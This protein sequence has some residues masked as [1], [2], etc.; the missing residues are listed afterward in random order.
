M[1]LNYDFSAP[2]L[3]NILLRHCCMVTPVRQWYWRLVLVD[4]L[5]LWVYY[6]GYGIYPG[7]IIVTSMKRE[8]SW[9]FIVRRIKRSGDFTKINNIVIDL[10]LQGIRYSAICARPSHWHRKHGCTCTWVP[11]PMKFLNGIPTM[12][13]FALKCFFFIL[14]LLS[15]RKHRNKSTR[16]PNHLPT[17]GHCK[18]TFFI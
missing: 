18:S 13:H 10:D 11:R 5:A 3:Q 15:V 8:T 9:I 4:Q 16:L 6:G 12:S 2:L 17:P 7:W 14:L 1:G